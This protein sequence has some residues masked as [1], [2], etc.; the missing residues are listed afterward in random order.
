M[1]THSLKHI[2]YLGL[3]TLSAQ[4]IHASDALTT[5]EAD[6]LTKEDLAAVQIL[7]EVCPALMS[8]HEG[9]Q[10]KIEALS[11]T[12]LGNL[13]SKVTLAQLQQ[14]SEYQLILKAAKNDAAEVEQAEQKAACEDILSLD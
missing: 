3:L 9:F 10:K 11:Q 14:D 8:H 2:F 6:T 12:F 13:S 7:T 4:T 1:Q 5:A